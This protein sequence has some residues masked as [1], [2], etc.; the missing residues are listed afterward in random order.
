M[1]F[2]SITVDQ[3]LQIFKKRTPS[4][5]FSCEFFKFFRI[6]FAQ[7]RDRSCKPVFLI[8]KWEAPVFVRNS[9]LGQPQNQFLGFTKIRIFV[10]MIYLFNLS[11]QLFMLYSSSLINKSDICYSNIEKRFPRDFE[12]C[13][14]YLSNTFVEALLQKYF[15]QTYYQRCLIEITQTP[16]FIVVPPQNFL[17]QFYFDKPWLT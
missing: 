4:Q 16:T 3:G 17:I 9:I 8:C 11:F 12:Q 2:V 13:I 7:N 1:K 15:C 6:S 5:A 10:L 14:Q